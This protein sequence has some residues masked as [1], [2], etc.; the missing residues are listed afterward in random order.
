MSH[1][2]SVMLVDDNETDNYIAR[3][4]IN[5]TNLADQIVDFTSAIQ[6]KEYLLQ[7]IRFEMFLHPDLMPRN[8][9]DVHI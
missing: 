7:N 1:R 3:S 8:Y 6:S 2:I 4:I 9:V 5:H